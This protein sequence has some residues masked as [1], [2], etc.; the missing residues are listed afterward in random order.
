MQSLTD[1]SDVE[2]ERLAEAVAREQRAR[3]NAALRSIANQREMFLP[4]RLYSG[5]RL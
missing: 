4:A 1:L 2:L 3:E 5:T